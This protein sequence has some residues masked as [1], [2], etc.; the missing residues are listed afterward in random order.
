MSLS[1]IKF[2][3]VDKQ[4]DVIN[5]LETHF[6]DLKN[7]EIIR[8]DLESIK[9]VD[10]IVAGHNS[11]GLMDNGVDKKINLLLNNIQPRIKFMIESTYTGELPVGNCII[12]KTNNQNYKYLAYCPT[13]RLQKDV[14]NTHNAYIAFRALLTAILNYNKLNEEKINSV[15]CTGFCTGH[16]KMDADKAGKQMRLAYSFVN[17]NMNCSLENA[18]I[19]DKLLGN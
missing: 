11:Y 7:V 16:G 2:F 14:S 9:T 12:L 17:I 15:L 18:K 4:R 19:I 6:S 5:A 13:M 3:I 10:C 8:G 1:N